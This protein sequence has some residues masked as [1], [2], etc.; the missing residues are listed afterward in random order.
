MFHEKEKNT[1]YRASYEYDE[2]THKYKNKPFEVI[3]KIKIR[4]INIK[5]G[6]SDVILSQDIRISANIE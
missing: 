1:Q 5:K 6:T 3:E 4:D 2:A